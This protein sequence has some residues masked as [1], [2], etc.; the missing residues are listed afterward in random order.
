MTALRNPYDR[1]DSL[2][3]VRPTCLIGATFVRIRAP[4]HGAHSQSTGVSQT[5]VASS[6]YPTPRTLFRNVGEDEFG[7]IFLRIRRTHASTVRGVTNCM[8]P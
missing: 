7:S 6:L 4:E 8:S 1:H 2:F 5:G 3:G